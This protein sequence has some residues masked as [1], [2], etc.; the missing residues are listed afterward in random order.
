M[1][2]TEKHDAMVFPIHVCGTLSPYPMVVTVTFE[3]KT[4]NKKTQEGEDE[5]SGRSRVLTML[6]AKKHTLFTEETLSG[7][8]KFDSKSFLM[9]QTLTVITSVILVT[10]PWEAGERWKKLESN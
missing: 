2:N 5:T 7:G 10:V 3:K 8:G 4:K 1:A 9:C 6:S